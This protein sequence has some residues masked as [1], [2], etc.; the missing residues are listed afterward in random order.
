MEEKDAQKYYEKDAFDNYRRGLQAGAEGRMEEMQ[1]Y[2]VRARTAMSA[3]DFRMADQT[4]I[5]KKALS[6]LGDLQDKVNWD[7]V[8]KA[9]ASKLPSRLDSFI[10]G[11]Q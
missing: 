3:G 5:Y 11:A 2:F 10:S 9:P 4:R 1:K 6:A 8:R 7:A